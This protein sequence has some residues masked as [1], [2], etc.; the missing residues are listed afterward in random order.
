MKTNFQDSMKRSNMKKYLYCSKC[1][2]Y[3]EKAIVEFSDFLIE[4][5]KWNGEDYEL[6]DSNLPEISNETRFICPVCK[7]ELIEK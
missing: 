6:Y 4:K 3:P 5:R 2:K 7:S 1:K